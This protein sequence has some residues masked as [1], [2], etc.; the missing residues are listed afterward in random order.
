VFHHLFERYGEIQSRRHDEEASEKGFTL[1]ELLIVIVVLGILAAIVIFSLTSVTGSS[2][3]SAC[4][5][6]AKTV[7]TAIQAYDAQNPNTALP[8]IS[9]TGAVVAPATG[10]NPLV[11]PYLHTW[12][13][14]D[15]NAGYKISYDGTN[16]QVTT[17]KGT[18]A[19]YDTNN[20]CNNLSS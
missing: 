9:T 6:D 1:I 12:P 8:A 14:A 7:E 16:V 17:P 15:S 19:A 20:L 3:A 10:S 5:A 4:N 13:A 18:T 2:A 11:G